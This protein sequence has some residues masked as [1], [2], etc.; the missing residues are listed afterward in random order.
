MAQRRPERSSTPAPRSGGRRTG[1]GASAKGAPRAARSKTDKRPSSPRQGEARPRAPKAGGPGRLARFVRGVAFLGLILLVAVAVTG[2]AVY[3]S[4]AR[5]LPDPDIAKA[6]GRDQTSVIYDRNGKILARLYAEENRQ[7]MALAKMPKHLR[8]AVIATE[9]RRFYEHTGVDPIGIARA[10]MVDI[11][12]GEKA[13]GGS[14]ITQQYVKQAFVTS[15]KT[16]RRKVQEAILAQ[17]V[18]RRYTKDQILENYLNT[19]YFGHGAYGVEAASRAYFGKSVA[20]LSVPE[21]AMIAG[22]IKSPGRFSPYID[23]DAALKRRSTVLAQMKAQGYLS[24]A[25]YRA[26][27]AA[28]LKVAGLKPR[29]TR[30]PYFV[31]WIKLQLVD[32]FGEAAVYRGGLRIKTTLDPQAQA[33]AEKAVRR[34]LNRKGD[35]SAALVAV[36]PGSGEILAMV[37]GRDFKKQQFNVA[38]QGK[39]QPG[40]AFK[41]FVLAA[42]LQ[43]GVSP[44][45]AYKSGPMKLQVGDDVWSVTGASGSSNRKMRLRPATEKSVNSVFAQLILEVGPDLVVRTAEKLGIA[46]GIEPVPAIALGGLEHGVSPLEM[47]NAYATL[48]AGGRRARPY[49]I[50]YV[51]DPSGQLLRKT[52]PKTVRAI[53]PAVAFLTT[54]IL[55]GVITRGTGTSAQIG[56]PAAGKTGTTQEYRDAWFVGYTPD[57]A[58]AVWVG[59]PDSQREMKS[60]H[61]RAVT[62]GSFPAEIWASFMRSVL[63]GKPKRTFKKPTGLSTV[64]VCSETG[65]L[66]TEFCP[67]PISALVLTEHEPES[68]EAHTEPIEVKLPKLTGLPKEDALARLESLKLK[69]KVIEKQVSGVAAGIVASQN[70]PAGT[71]VKAD[72]VVTLVVSAGAAADLPPQA[73]FTSPDS[74]KSGKPAAF[75]A[76]G[77]TDD[78]TITTYYWEFGDGQTATGKTVTHTWS[79]PGTYEVTLW[80]TDNG[81]QQGSV[82]K[83]VIVK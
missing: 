23:P 66:V 54:D 5:Q 62:G 21:A 26:A 68:C 49:A 33:A 38:V 47:A 76:T 41:P 51:K 71:S 24:A 83:A 70:P 50:T 32:E 57:I 27:L 44:E 35:P 3:S 14:T 45:K 55:R 74:P 77:S 36:R 69:A 25:E 28:P 2:C 61:G 82:T 79:T 9:D 81:G 40:S 65:G 29:A 34:T 6:R 19:I 11:V 52:T 67:K 72:A 78:G 18:E 64:K 15:E 4:M 56:R 30:A 39:R 12:R 60:V 7:D 20:R 59:Y 63:D 10:L 22:V 42:A 17:R 13:Q 46:K 48:A 1:A 58:T 80:V 16:L 73:S 37:G 43:E 75:D 8:Q 31:E 53:D